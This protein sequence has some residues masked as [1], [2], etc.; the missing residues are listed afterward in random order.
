MYRNLSLLTLFT[1]LFVVAG[2]GGEA[3]DTEAAREAAREAVQA[4]ESAA[5]QATE[6]AVSAAEA[7]TEAASAEADLPEGVTAAML[8]T[9]EA[10]YRG[11]GICFTCHGPNGAGVPG[12]GSSLTDSE[13]LHSD[14]SI[15]G[16]IATVTEGVSAAQSS[17]GVPMM[18]RGGA[19][20][21]DEQIRAVSAYVWTL[22]H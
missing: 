19:N 3:P 16:I 9:G 7:V 14:G 11:A 13:W 6:T 4:V 2:C 20:I 17:T 5:E 1:T 8:E 22:S 10:V 12:L 18:P 15:E 21:N